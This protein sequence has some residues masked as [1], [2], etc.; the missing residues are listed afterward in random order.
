MITQISEYKQAARRLAET[1]PERKAYVEL[2]RHATTVDIGQ[3]TKAAADG[4]I[5]LYDARRNLSNMTNE[6]LAAGLRLA[7]ALSTDTQKLTEFYCHPS[8]DHRTPNRNK[9]LLACLQFAMPPRNVRERKL[10]SKYAA[11]VSWLVLQGHGPDDLAQGVVAKEGGR[12]ACARK[13]AAWRRER[14]NASADRSDRSARTELGAARRKKPTA[15]AAGAAAGVTSNTA[16]LRV[17][18]AN[19]LRQKIRDREP[20]ADR[21]HFWARVRHRG[22]R[23]SIVEIAPGPPN[24]PTKALKLAKPV[25]SS[26]REQPEIRQRRRLIAEVRRIVR[27]STDRLA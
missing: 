2:L 26:R 22:E 21:K 5:S 14:K 27:A 1:G 10:L 4:A 18:F 12:S 13:L 6:Q 11:V 17:R 8:W 3:L 16:R 25:S 7:L 24:S 19:G 20:P 9:L 23:I 15:N